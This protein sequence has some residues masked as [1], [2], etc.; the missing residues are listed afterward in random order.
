MSENPHF[1][2][3]IFVVP[4]LNQL[5]VYSPLHNFAALMNF[6][7]VVQLRRE[8]L[9]EDSTCVG[10]LG[11]IVPVLKSRGKPVPSKKQGGFAPEFLGLL[12][13]R[14]CNL[15]C[16]YCGFLSA[17]ESGKVMD[18]KLV[19]D[20][21]DWYMNLVSQ[22]NGQSVEIHY[23]GGEPFCA[24]EVVDFGFHFARTKARELGYTTRFEV[25]TN[26][27]FTQS[28][29]QW[30]ADNLDTVVLSLD[31]PADIHDQHRPRRG[32]TGSFETV[33]RNAKILS[34]G[35]AELCIRTCVAA[36][37]V[38]RMEEIAS[39]LCQS[40]HPHA[41]CFEPVQPTAQ[42]REAGLF[43]PDPWRFAKSFIKAARILEAYGVE[44]IYAASDISSL[45]VTFCPV[46]QDVAIVSPDG[47]IS[48]CY[49]LQRDWEAKGLDL[50]LGSIGDD[51]SVSMGTNAVE[52]ARDMNVLN[53]PFCAHCFC[54]WHCAGGCHVNHVLP[55]RH[56]DYDDLCIQTR[57]ITLRNILKAMDREE[58]IDSLLNNSPEL[59]ESVCQPSDS[60]FDFGNDDG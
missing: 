40:Y 35:A 5:L 49:L 25:A 20:A 51:G 18:L 50:R 58:L 21:V 36:E 9:S 60:L 30:V 2:G 38:D 8:L 46:G 4:V 32:G 29:C 43:P 48:A 23:F 28:R 39:W 22:S 42:S 3:E 14:D 59:E 6:A 12:P 7:S 33:A 45:R 37:T 31:G 11:Q 57:I 16:K 53:K 24:E 13:T 56:G 41:V 1:V 47:V 44:P 26:G 34:E 27:T 17:D 52:A 19:R 15:S 10:Q 54:K 55:E